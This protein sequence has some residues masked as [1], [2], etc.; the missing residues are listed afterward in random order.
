MKRFL[1]YL[2]CIILLTSATAAYA[3]EGN[4]LQI[5]GYQL[6][7]S[8]LDVLLYA[9]ADEYFSDDNISVQF[10]DV[11]IQT[12]KLTPY[13]DSNYGTSWIVIVEPTNSNSA[14][15]M[16]T[17]LVQSVMAKFGKKDNIAVYN[18]YANTKTEFL[19]SE[20]S[21]M[22]LLENTLSSNGDTNQK[23]R[24]YDTVNSALTT[25]STDNNLNAH[26][27]LL[28]ISRLEDNGST[29][30]FND[31]SRKASDLPIT[32]YTVGL[33]GF[34]V[35]ALTPK[36]EAFS[37]LS[38][39]TGSGLAISAPEIKQ[40]NGAPLAKQIT[41]N[42]KNNLYVFSVPFSAELL[43]VPAS[44]VPLNLTLQLKNSKLEATLPDF[45]G[46]AL[47][48]ALAAKSITSHEHEWIEATCTE[49]K[50]CSVCGETEGDP[51]GHDWKEA[52]CT[53]PKTCSVCGET[54]GAP[55]G[56][57]YS[58]ASFF[59]RGVCSR[60]GEEVPSKVDEIIEWAKGNPILAA[61]AAVLGIGILV[62]IIVL[63]TK[64][65]KSGNSSSVGTEPSEENI[66]TLPLINDKV[67]IALTNVKTG[68]QFT[69]GIRG[70]SIKAGR[71]AALTLKGDPSISGTHMEFVWQN[72]CL[73]VQDAN[74]TNGTM[75]N[76]KE[77]HGAVAL[78]QNDMIH[79]GTSDFRVNWHSNK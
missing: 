37:A 75:V 22:P 18:A 64:K 63:L 62:L 41:D 54:E 20:A 7:D 58:K 34:D 3:T 67:T 55:L 14:K 44:T 45:D 65:K 68:E 70:T 30:Y 61:M 5:I 29:S 77:V 21:V 66:E 1:S 15:L 73:Y 50:T 8:D 27:C 19:N 13:V 4:G 43:D 46:A 9:K 47:Q 40:E 79:V 16:T 6:T 36:F 57:D 78:N 11:E 26:K 48:E 31:L 39:A 35:K 76:G 71:S 28:V 60:C 17:T 25:F 74:S 51:L 72:G 33:T 2:L 69:G 52:T 59:K 24:L 53:E 23:M 49:P 38:A 56:H 12:D 10:G 32:I 42:E